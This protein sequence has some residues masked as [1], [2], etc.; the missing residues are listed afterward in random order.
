MRDSLGEGGQFAGDVAG[1]GCA[2]AL[3]DL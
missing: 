1:L 2:D 3:E